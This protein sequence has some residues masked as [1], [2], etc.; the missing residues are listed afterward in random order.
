M[1]LKIKHV[2]PLAATAVVMAAGCYN[3]KADQLYPEPTNPGGGGNTCDT[4]N[5]SFATNIKPILKQFCTDLGCH[6][7]NGAPGTYLLNAYGG[8]KTYVD[9][10]RLLGAIRHENGFTAMPQGTSKLSDCNINK[11]TAWVN[12]GALD[13]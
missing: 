3:D 9:N 4:A 12:Q 13:N 6:T 5:M 1:K 10:N 7:G 2:L 11:I 8:T